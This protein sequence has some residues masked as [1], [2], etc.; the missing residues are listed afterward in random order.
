MV[1]HARS[2]EGR[3]EVERKERLNG[4]LLLPSYFIW[5]VR[6]SKVGMVA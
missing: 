1:R 3:A 5:L 2:S 6:G 4:T